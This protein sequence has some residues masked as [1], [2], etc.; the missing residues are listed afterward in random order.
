MSITQSVHLLLIHVI[1]TSLLHALSSL[2]VILLSLSKSFNISSW[3]YPT[4]IDRND[5]N[6]RLRFVNILRF[7][8]IHVLYT[9][10][11]TIYYNIYIHIIL[12]IIIMYTAV[13]VNIVNVVNNHGKILN[14][15]E[16]FEKI[17]PWIPQLWSDLI[18][19]DEWK[20]I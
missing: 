20:I 7:T 17:R 3:S 10:M 6:F 4:S 19:R 11:G 13:R 5:I 16:H 12:Y 15:N 2:C 14:T 9:M 8:G 18:V 1:S